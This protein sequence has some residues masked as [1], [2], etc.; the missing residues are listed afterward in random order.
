[1][2]VK[3]EGKITI[4]VQNQEAIRSTTWR[5]ALSHKLAEVKRAFADKG[6]QGPEIDVSKIQFEKQK[7]RGKYNR[8]IGKHIYTC[9]LACTLNSLRIHHAIDSNDTEDKWISLLGKKSF[10][11]SGFLSL[12]SIKTVLESLKNSTVVFETRMT[13]DRLPDIF[14]A[15]SQGKTIIIFSGAHSVLLLGFFVEKDTVFLRLHDPYQ[16]GIIQ[17]IDAESYFLSLDERIN[18]A[19]MSR[20]RN[21]A[22]EIKIGDNGLRDQNSIERKNMNNTGRESGVPA[23]PVEIAAKPREI[24]D[25]TAA[26]FVD[27]IKP[28][29]DL[30]DPTDSTIAFIV[31]NP[32][33]FLSAVKASDLDESLHGLTSPSEND[34]LGIILTNLATAYVFGG[35]KGLLA[36][37]N[38][39]NDMTAA[40]SE[41][42]AEPVVKPQVAKP[43]APAIGK[44]NQDT[45]QRIK[46]GKIEE[47]Q[48]ENQRPK[49]L[50]TR[51]KLLW[52]ILGSED[53]SREQLMYMFTRA[54]LPLLSSL[55]VDAI[56]DT[57]IVLRDE[58][59]EPNAEI[60]F[61]DVKESLPGFGKGA[62]RYYST[63]PMI[64]RLVTAYAHSAEADVEGDGDGD[65]EDEDAG[66]PDEVQQQEQPKEKKS[67]LGVLSPFI[68]LDR[69]KQRLFRREKNLV[70]ADDPKYDGVQVDGIPYTGPDNDQDTADSEPVPE[71]RTV[72]EFKL[73]TRLLVEVKDRV[74]KGDFSYELIGLCQDELVRAQMSL[75]PDKP[76]NKVWNQQV[77]K[78]ISILKDVVIRRIAEGQFADI[79]SGNEEYDRTPK[80]GEFEHIV[81]RAKTAD[82]LLQLTIQKVLEIDGHF[83]AYVN[84]SYKDGMQLDT[85]L[86]DTQKKNLEFHIILVQKL[87]IRYME[88]KQEE[89][90]PADE[91]LVYKIYAGLFQAF[92]LY[93]VR[94]K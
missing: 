38:Y 19:F 63:P 75:K 30:Y 2:T 79:L 16:D 8:V 28:V 74:K 77:Q 34:D 67:W 91:D 42:V 9:A 5:E 58:H 7:Y 76:E 52:R 64:Q 72:S 4:S 41:P 53:V 43:A 88:M 40:S 59:D 93:G 44:D 90:Q 36:I 56:V 35:E 11:D 39:V 82:Q 31:K 26:N 27:L 57:I 20:E 25:K 62:V 89:N 24:T 65:G 54:G 84:E 29:I 70:E 13:N 46:F 69:I 73:D 37:N 85:L 86:D 12:E 94:V 10:D 51:E 80:V 49:E 6:T 45:K 32:K 3:N 68:F 1:M 33:V 71:V 21:I 60:T 23:V 15:L 83:K 66:Q 22:N 81:D 17:T 50:L 18:L 87:L 61:E 48:E 47:E 55:T 92:S 78:A 14:D